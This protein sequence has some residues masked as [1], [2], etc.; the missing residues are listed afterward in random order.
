MRVPLYIL[1]LTLPAV[2]WGAQMDLAPVDAASAAQSSDPDNQQHTAGDSADADPID[3]EAASITWVDNSHAY[4]TERAQK[5]TEWMDGFFGDPV[6]DLEKPESLLRLEWE[7]TWDEVDDYKTRLRLRGKVRL[8]ALSERINIIF[9]GEDGDPSVERDQNNEDNAEILYNLGERMRQRLDVTLGL[10]SSGLK[11]G[12]RYR[13]Q[14]PISDN[15]RYRY[16]HRLEWEKNEGFYT[17][18]QVNLDHVLSDTQLIRWGSRLTYGEETY[19]LDWR[20]GI[21]YRQKFITPRLRDPFVLSM[22]TTM[23]GFTDPSWI[24]NYRVGM[25]FRRQLFRRY[26][27]ME[28]EPSYN[29]R[30]REDEAHR[31][32]AWNIVLRFEILF[33]TGRRRTPETL[34]ARRNQGPTRASAN[35]PDTN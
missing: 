10:N 22:F 30:K 12:V 23:N 31:K 5:L 32:R 15:Y 17:T 9:S 25:R 6:Y 26:L 20:T 3:D 4:A 27:F 34:S 18:A 21:S 13:N 2:S 11:P 8:P 19:G 29:F 14:G 33:E 24:E 7:N 1:L 16:T 35:A 28:V